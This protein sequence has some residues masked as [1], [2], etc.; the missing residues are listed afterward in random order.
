MKHSFLVFFLLFFTVSTA[1]TQRIPVVG[2]M[3]FEAVGT[4]VSDTDAANKT[5]GIIE[6]LRSWGT[7]NIVQDSTGVDY[8]IQGT[9][10]QQGGNFVLSGKT[11]NASGQ[12]LNEYTEGAQTLNA[13][14]IMMFC[15]RAIERITLPNHLLGTWQSTINTPHGPIT[16]IIEFR[17]D[18][19]V[20]VE[21]YDTWEQSQNN[22]LRYEGF[23]TGTYTYTGFANRIVT[24]NNRQ[25]RIDAIAS[26]NLR[27]EDTLPGQASINQSNLQILFNSDKTSFEILN[28]MLPSGRNYD[29]SSTHPSAR[30]GFSQFTRIQ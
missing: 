23:G 20:R 22:T 6:E 13:I 19:T 30:V 4:A 14:S 8:I 10:S 27:L 18:R 21:R 16:S 28:N 7:L 25:V 15:T 24:I 29:V 2:V 3:Q 12:V 26:V 5:I 1:Y 17:S 11:L 9:L